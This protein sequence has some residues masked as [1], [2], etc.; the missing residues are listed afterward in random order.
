MKYLQVKLPDD[1]HD[2]FKKTCEQN[3]IG[4]S[5]VVKSWINRYIKKHGA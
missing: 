5:K 1:M 3:K 2:N 4:M